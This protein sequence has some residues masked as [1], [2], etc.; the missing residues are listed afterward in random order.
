MGFIRKLSNRFVNWATYCNAVSV[1][2]EASTPIRKRGANFTNGEFEDSTGLS[3][4]VYSAKSGGKIIQ[5]VSYDRL[6]DT[7]KTGL[8]IIA[9]ED[10]FGEELAQIITREMLSR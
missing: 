10:D 6:M 1:D 7:R 5:T 2:M 3:F 8:Y 4:V 9:N